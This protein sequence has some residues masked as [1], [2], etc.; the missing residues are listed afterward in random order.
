MN[1]P[2]R[3]WLV[4]YLAENR[5]VVLKRSLTEAPINC[6][7]REGS[8]LLSSVLPRPLVYRNQS[9]GAGATRINSFRNVSARAHALRPSLYR[10]RK[11]LRARVPH[12]DIA[13]EISYAVTATVQRRLVLRVTYTH[14]NATITALIAWLYVRRRSHSNVPSAI[15]DNLFSSA[16]Y[17]WNP[18]E[19]K[20]SR[21][22]TNARPCILRRD[23]IVD[24]RGVA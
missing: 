5:P 22:R 15:V 2:L 3:P 20:T 23:A 13:V 7:D 24:A 16:S 6:E 14:L 9:A 10:S 21:V 19:R 1:A 11:R 8:R 4:F 17:R 18:L 12:E